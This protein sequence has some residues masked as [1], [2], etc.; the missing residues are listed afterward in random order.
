MK[1]YR[2]CIVQQLRTS[3][4]LLFRVNCNNVMTVARSYVYLAPGGTKMN[5]HACSLLASARVQ[6]TGVIMCLRTNGTAVG[7]RSLC[8]SPFNLSRADQFHVDDNI[9]ER[10]LLST[11]EIFDTFVQAYKVAEKK[12]YDNETILFE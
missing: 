8:V 5:G 11:Q 1:V 7:R 10:A 9:D 3:H 12:N 4:R 6:V 2:V